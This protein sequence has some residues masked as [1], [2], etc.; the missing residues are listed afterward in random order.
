[1]AD[2]EKD[3]AQYESVLGTISGP[4]LKDWK[5]KVPDLDKRYTEL[6]ETPINYRGRYVPL[7]YN[8]KKGSANPVKA[9]MLA[10][11]IA[12]AKV[13]F[14]RR[15]SLN[16]AAAMLTKVGLNITKA[17]LL[18]VFPRYSD[19]LG[20]TEHIP[21]SDI[22]VVE[23]KN[24]ADAEEL[25]QRERKNFAKKA[26]KEGLTG[27][28]LKEEMTSLRK[29]GVSRA[30]KKTERTAE[31]K[32]ETM[33]DEFKGR[34]IVYEP[35]PKQAL[36]HAA[37][38]KIVL[39][40]GAAGGGKSYALIFDAIRYAHVPRYRALIIRRTMP[41]LMELIETSKEF[42]PKLFPGCKF[43]TQKNMWRFPSGAIL[44]FGYLDKPGDKL[45]YQGQQYQYIAFDELGQWPDA[46]GWNYL[47]SRLRK[48]PIDPLTGKKIP[49]LMRATSNPGA[50]WV[51]EMFID[52][53]PANTTYYDR[54]GV[55][56][57][58]IPAT[59]LDNP[60]LDADYRMM[61][62]SLPELERR[63]LLYGDWNA[64]DSAAFPEFRPDGTVETDPITG[65]TVEYC[66]PHVVEPFE[67]PK[68]WN[69][70]CGMDY[71]YRD[72][73]T[74]IWYAINPTNGQ[75]IVYK[76]YSESGKTGTEYAKDVLKLE[77]DEVIPID[78]VL[79]WSV[80]NKTG[81]TGPT[82]GEE[83]RRVGLVVRPADKNRVGGKVQIHEHLRPMPGSKEPAMVI[84]NTC[85]GIIGQLKAAQIK[86]ND[87]DDIDQTRVGEN[88][89]HHWDL[90]DA[91]R[92]GV[93]ARPTREN[94][95]VQY[96]QAKQQ[97]RWNKVNS[98]FS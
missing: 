53:A 12:L 40:G 87:P 86:E 29:T 9:H 82:I 44:E 64:T 47:K 19:A 90:Y 93:M 23:I 76:E 27:E 34:E 7:G 50:S 62:E 60:H 77:E 8:G 75:K 45:R 30:S 49:T 22:K 52:A 5:K 11:I 72:P 84:F 4:I 73:A 81:H 96:R 21:N 46:E 66:T 33:S 26:K 95:L 94:R 25:V 10:I 36:F 97:S 79:D 67:I 69:R 91:L 70:V 71:G 85:T 58:F 2:F 1:M 88:H 43:N 20:L 54:A 61:L 59:L 83:I 80:F 16:E 57:K 31:S 68:W 35:T 51:K 24:L 98:Y 6:T 55:S 13:K 42:Y 56:H 39:Y 18:K 74:A 3:L 37:S 38:E 92:Y 28:E 48:P 14:E 32:E 78:H 15:Y 89:K 63:Q 65:N 41:E 17:G